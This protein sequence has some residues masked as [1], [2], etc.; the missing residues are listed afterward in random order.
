MANL[1]RL[2]FM[3]LLSFCLQALVCHEN[4]SSHSLMYLPSFPHTTTSIYTLLRFLVPLSEFLF[5]NKLSTSWV[6]I[7][8]SWGQS[9]ADSLF[10]M[11][12]SQI[13]VFK[14]I[15]NFLGFYSNSKFP[16]LG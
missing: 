1:G 10:L 9:C 13:D 8:V 15:L 2:H 6:K 11:Y 14:P 7:T 16:H 12:L 4:R 3:Y 5:H